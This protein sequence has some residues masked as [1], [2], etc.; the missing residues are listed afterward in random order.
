MI[1]KINV[2]LPAIEQTMG[3]SYY[4]CLDQCEFA[5]DINFKKREDLSIIYKKLVETSYF[6]FNC[7]DIYSFFGRKVEYIGRF[8]GEIISDLR[9]RK[10]GFRIKFKMNKNQIKMYDKGNN[11]PYQ[12]LIIYAVYWEVIISSYSAVFLIN[13]NY[14]GLV[15]RYN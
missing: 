3:H 14:I 7:H 10:Q 2:H 6:A 8:K 15:N 12:R 13:Q 1:K 5:T 11:Q 4:W 9:N